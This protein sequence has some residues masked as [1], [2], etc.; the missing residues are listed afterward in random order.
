M[1]CTECKVKA[2]CAY[3]CRAI[4]FDNLSLKVCIADIT[5]ATCKGKAAHCNACDTKSLKPEDHCADNAEMCIE[6]VCRQQTETCSGVD[7]LRPMSIAL[8]LLSAAMVL[9]N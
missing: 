6:S 2:D 3:D 8:V 1:A 4:W 7:K 9:F 5:F